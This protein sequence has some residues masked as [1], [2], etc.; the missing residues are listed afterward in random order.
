MLCTNKGLVTSGYS[1]AYLAHWPGSKM[2][3]RK[4]SS[5]FPYICMEL[6]SVFMSLGRLLGG[7]EY[8]WDNRTV[9]VDHM[10]L[11]DSFYVLPDYQTPFSAFFFIYL[12]Y[13]LFPIISLL[14]IVCVNHLPPP[15]PWLCIMTQRRRNWWGLY[16]CIMLIFNRLI[17]LFLPPY[18][19]ESSDGVSLSF[20]FLFAYWLKAVVLV[21]N[22]MLR[23]TCI[24]FQNDIANGL[25]MQVSYTQL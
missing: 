25:P 21:D 5:V 10:G 3:S 24:P 4:R 19:F 9:V 18:C 16:L 12:F 15:P 11:L 2:T 13:L 1:L 7:R 20:C 14:R 6:F 8:I 23:M 22:S 17:C